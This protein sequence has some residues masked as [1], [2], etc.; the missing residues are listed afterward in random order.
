[1]RPGISLDHARRGGL[2]VPALVA[3]VATSA[4]AMVGAQVTDLGPWYRNLAKPWWQPPD[5]LFPPAWTLIFTLT[6]IAGVLAWR[7]APDRATRGRLLGLFAL[8]AILNVAWSAIFFT[9]QRPDYALAEVALLWLSIL[10]LIGLTWRFA[11]GASLLLVPYLLW[12]S[13]ASVL[14]LAVV[15]LNGPFG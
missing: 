7:T 9:L 4:V 15:R 13:F 5:W 11:R 1:M 6:A 8:N 2:V 12:V 3:A 14:N 10:A